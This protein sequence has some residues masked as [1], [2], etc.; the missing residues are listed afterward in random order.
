MSLSS[1][2]S[3]YCCVVGDLIPTTQVCCV[4]CWTP[5]VGW[6][7]P[8]RKDANPV[9]LQVQ[10]RKYYIILRIYRITNVRKGHILWKMDMY[11]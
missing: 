4:L 5:P 11:K 3:Y 1:F 6:C 7:R 10:A 9:A 8:F 2:G